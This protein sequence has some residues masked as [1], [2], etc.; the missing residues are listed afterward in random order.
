[1]LSMSFENLKNEIDRVKNFKFE[2]RTEEKSIKGKLCCWMDTDNPIPHSTS[3]LIEEDRSSNPTTFLKLVVVGIFLTTLG[4]VSL[5]IQWR[6]LKSA[7]QHRKEHRKEEHQE[8]G[9]SPTD[10]S[11]STK[12]FGEEVRRRHNQEI[13]ELAAQLNDMKQMKN[14]V[15]NQLAGLQILAERLKE[16]KGSSSAP[17]ANQTNPTGRKKQN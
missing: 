10:N 6:R 3:L 16:K 2:Q 9:K 5:S 15:K 11:F 17:S 1:M 7:R 4:F 14:D 12:R 13:N 8:L